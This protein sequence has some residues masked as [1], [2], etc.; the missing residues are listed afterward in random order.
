MDL[1]VTLNADAA[2][3]LGIEM[4]TIFPTAEITRDGNC[5]AVQGA[6]AHEMRILRRRVEAIDAAARKERERGQISN[7][8][9]KEIPPFV[10]G[11]MRIARA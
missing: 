10:A 1:N 11:D 7:L 3:I 8:S 2:E 9:P 6:Y 4:A 5:F